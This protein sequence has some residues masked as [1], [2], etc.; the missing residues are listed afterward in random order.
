[1]KDHVQQ[2]NEIE[3]P[4][5]NLTNRQVEILDQISLGYTNQNI[6]EKLGISVKTV[7]AHRHRIFEKMGVTNAPECVR[8]AMS[9]GVLK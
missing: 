5:L 7:E 2:F 9:I 6:A 1:M 8:V 4:M 3:V